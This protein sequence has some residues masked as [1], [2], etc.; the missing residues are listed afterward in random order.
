MLVSMHEVGLAGLRSLHRTP[1][2]PALFP[3]H[4]AW[5]EDVITLQTANSAQV[6]VCGSGVST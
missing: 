3:S 1:T 5:S 2:L 4:P 6:L